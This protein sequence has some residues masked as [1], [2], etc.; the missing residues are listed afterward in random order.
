VLTLFFIFSFSFFVPSPRTW[1]RSPGSDGGDRRHIIH[2]GSR[3]NS[4]NAKRSLSTRK[5]KGKTPG[6]DNGKGRSKRRS[7][8]D[9][10]KNGSR[11]SQAAKMRAAQAMVEFEMIR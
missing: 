10:S 4:S 1:A 5:P 9:R 8:G 6:T 7:G 11:V 2:H 3:S